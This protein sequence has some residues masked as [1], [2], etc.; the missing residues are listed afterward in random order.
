MKKNNSFLLKVMFATFFLAASFMLAQQNYTISTKV[1][2]SS[3]HYTDIPYKTVDGKKV[4]LDIFLPKTQDQKSFPVVIQIHG[5]GWVEGNKDIPADTY[6]EKTVLQFLHNGFAVVSIDYRLASKEVHFPAMIEDTKDAIRWVRKNAAQYGFDTHNIGT[7]GG[8]AGGHLALLAAYSAD[9]DFVGDADLAHYSSKCNYVLDN[10]GPTELS[11]IFQVNAGKFKLWIMK[12]F[13]PKLIDIR[14]KLIFAVTGKL[15]SDQTKPEINTFMD[16]ISPLKFV[17]NAVPTQILH[18]NKDQVVPLSESEN[19][20]TALQNRNIISE[21]VIV[22]KGNHGFS[23]ISEEQQ[24]QLAQK[25]VDF[26]KSQL[27]H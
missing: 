12:L 7:W 24:N 17:D 16:S 8:S 4:A 1:P 11:A 20:R 19:L 22:D 21:L 26:A 13:A 3:R 14:S 23:N 15:I 27:L 2:D 18:G 9:S 25:M 6:T 5:G 10:F